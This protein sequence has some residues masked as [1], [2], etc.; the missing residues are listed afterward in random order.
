MN[1]L[2]HDRSVEELLERLRTLR[3]DS[4]RRWGRMS[5][6]QMVCHLNDSLRMATGEKLVKAAPRLH[7]RTLVKC[8]ALYTPLP[9]PAGIMTAPEVDQ[10]RGG[11]PPLEFAADLRELENRVRSFAARRGTRTPW[12]A[13]PIFGRMSEAQWL[14]WSYLHT[15]HHL[16]QFGA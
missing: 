8:L 7:Q 5:V 13:H 4:A 1:T 11:T 9:W 14:R 10:E 6:H 16:R 2:G 3:P 15:D 12:P